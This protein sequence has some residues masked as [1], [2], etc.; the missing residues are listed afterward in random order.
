MMP[1]SGTCAQYLD[2]S[3]VLMFIIQLNMSSRAV[4]YAFS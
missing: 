4:L 3:I 2:Q 1:K